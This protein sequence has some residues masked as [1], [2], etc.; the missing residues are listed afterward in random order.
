MQG[1]VTATLAHYGRSRG[2]RRCGSHFVTFRVKAVTLLFV[3]QAIILISILA[4]SFTAGRGTG[5]LSTSGL[6]SNG[7]PAINRPTKERVW[8]EIASRV[9]LALCG[10]AMTALSAVGQRAATREKVHDFPLVG[11][12]VGDYQ[13]VFRGLLVRGPIFVLPRNSAAAQVV[14]LKKGGQ[15]TTNLSGRVSSTDRQT[16]LCSHY[17]NR[18]LSEGGYRVSVT[19]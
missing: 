17:E 15:R 2:E 6:I 5:G 9:R 1:R 18:H 4:H 16:L 8:C 3:G 13:A 19:N 7:G 14:P 11:H 10:L 12:C